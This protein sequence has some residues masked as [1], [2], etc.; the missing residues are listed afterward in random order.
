MNKLM[1]SPDSVQDELAEGSFPCRRR[2]PRIAKRRLQP[3]NPSSVVCGPVFLAVER[4]AAVLAVDRH[5]ALAKCPPLMAAAARSVFRAESS[6]SARDAFQRRPPRRRRRPMLLRMPGRA[7][8]IAIVLMNAL[9]RTAFL[10]SSRCPWHTRART[11]TYRFCRPVDAG[12]AGPAEPIQLTA[13]ARI[14]SLSSPTSGRDRRS[15]ARCDWC[16]IYVATSA[17]LMPF[18]GQRTQYRFAELL[19]MD[20]RQGPLPPCR[21]PPA[22]AC[23]MS[24][25]QP[26]CLPQFFDRCICRRPIKC[27]FKAAS[28]PDER[29]TQGP[30]SVRP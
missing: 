2:I 13:L 23:T 8:E 6:T 5:E 27:H 25:R 9:R 10:E 1:S 29:S 24:T 30:C 28:P 15:A 11:P 4:G 17:V 19:R 26:W 14:H 18:V 21:C 20:A 3:A 12:D 16:P 7:G 22:P